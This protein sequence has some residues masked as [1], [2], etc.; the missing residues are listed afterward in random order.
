MNL[1]G[2]WGRGGFCLHFKMHPLDRARSIVDLDEIK[3]AD[4]SAVLQI[5]ASIQPAVA[6]LDGREL[7]RLLALSGFHRVARKN[8]TVIG[9]MFSFPSE[10]FYDG[11][12]FV[13]FHQLARAPFVYV[14]QLGISPEHQRRGIGQLF[15]S[16]LRHEASHVGAQSICC[17][18]NLAPPNPASLNFHYQLGFVEIASLHV[19][20]GRTVAL[21]E[22]RLNG[23]E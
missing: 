20:D 9:Y 11:E 7:S 16:T 21:L 3:P 6:R 12:E 23:N 8:G 2:Q 13:F 10:S 17:E 5:N 19:T 1:R 22:R 14:D 18:V 15:Y 4:W